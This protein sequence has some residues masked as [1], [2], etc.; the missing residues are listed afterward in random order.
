MVHSRGDEPAAI[1][2]TD[3]CGQPRAGRL[4]KD[5]HKNALEAKSMPHTESLGIED[6]ILPKFCSS[7]EPRLLDLTCLE[8]GAH[9]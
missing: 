4:A 7:F 6:M 9:R 3:E 8:E 1:S 5:V 2:S